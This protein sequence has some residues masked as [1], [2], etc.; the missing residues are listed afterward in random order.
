MADYCGRKLGL[1]TTTFNPATW[2]KVLRAQ[3][4]AARSLTARAPADLISVLEMF[5]PG[6]RSVVIRPPKHWGRYLVLPSLA[7]SCYLAVGL[8][9]LQAW[10]ASRMGGEPLR[11]VSLA[12]TWVGVPD[13]I[14]C[15]SPTM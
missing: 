11:T 14:T 1:P 5:F 3:E 2:G 15:P 7:I 10:R 6:D 9:M 8:M 4:P 12:R 13:A